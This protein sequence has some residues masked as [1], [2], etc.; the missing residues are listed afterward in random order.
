MEK[1]KGKARNS[2]VYIYEGYVYN[3]DKRIRDTYRCATRR[4]TR[5][6]GLAVVNENGKV[7]VNT[8]HDHPPNHIRMQK[9]A[10]EQE[11]LLL[12]R[13]SS[14]TPKDIFDDVSRK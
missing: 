14:Q 5:C 11:M 8:L 13:V 12:S 6:R 10:L 3:I 9:Y 7:T 4:T 1:I 2:F